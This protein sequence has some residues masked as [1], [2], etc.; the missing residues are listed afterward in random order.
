MSS[1]RGIEIDFD[2]HQKI[3]L[4]RKSFDETPNDVLRRLLGISEKTEPVLPKASDLVAN[5]KP[6]SGK[7]VI[8]P[9]GTEIR[10]EYNGELH[11]GVIKEGK[12]H[13]GNAVARSPS[14]AAKEAALTKD[15]KKPSLNGW[16]Y[17]EVKRPEDSSWR[18]LKDLK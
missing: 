13:V 15:G 8:L 2:V 12:W 7:G 9:H 16:I 4:A 14:D 5:G 1:K 10:M 11:S 3:E 18:S 6:W 17:W